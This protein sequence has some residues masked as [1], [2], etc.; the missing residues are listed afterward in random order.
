MRNED[1]EIQI[2][3]SAETPLKKDSGK[4]RRVWIAAWTAGRLYSS[5][6]VYVFSF[7]CLHSKR[8][9]PTNS[10][11]KSHLWLLKKDWKRNKANQEFTSRLI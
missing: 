4:N 11:L 6:P 2:L 7:S 9:L 8:L 3:G 5:S 1:D 10:S